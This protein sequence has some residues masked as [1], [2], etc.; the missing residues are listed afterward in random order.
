[1]LT[2]TAIAPTA[3]I[4]AL[5]RRTLGIALAEPT[6]PARLLRR[7]DV[8]FDGMERFLAELDVGEPVGGQTSPA[9]ATN[10]PAGGLPA[11]DRRAV[12]DRMRY[13]GYIER[14]ERDLER[15]RREETR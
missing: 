8:T 11:R 4:A 14:Q 12:A 6:T 9:V 10:A 5:A 7:S 1:L 13:G 15:L 3:T 2:D